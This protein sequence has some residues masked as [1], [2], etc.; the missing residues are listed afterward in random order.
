MFN[1]HLIRM[2]KNFGDNNGEKPPE[3][4]KALVT[5]SQTAPFGQK[6]E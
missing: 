6:L 5:L 2:K 1:G 3:G 4:G